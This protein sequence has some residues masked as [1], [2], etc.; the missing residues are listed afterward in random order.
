MLYVFDVNETLLDLAG[1]DDTLGGGQN[2]RVW[3]GCVIRGGLV[4]VAT[5]VYR[6]FADLA[7]KT[8]RC[9]EDAGFR[10]PVPDARACGETPV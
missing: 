8:C 2:R 1:L 7:V 10:M 9:L 6:D 5:S 4:C 3:F